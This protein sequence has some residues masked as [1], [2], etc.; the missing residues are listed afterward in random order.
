MES[1]ETP[2]ESLSFRP[3]YMM[4]RDTPKAKPSDEQNTNPNPIPSFFTTPYDFGSNTATYVSEEIPTNFEQKTY[5]KSTLYDLRTPH[6]VYPSPESVQ[7]MKDNEI[8]IDE[9]LGSDIVTILKQTSLQSQSTDYGDKSR[10]P[11]IPG[12]V[13]ENPTGTLLQRI[14]NKLTVDKFEPLVGELI[15]VMKNIDHVDTLKYSVNIIHKRAQ[16]EINFCG[17]YANMC[18]RLVN[19]CKTFKV[20]GPDGTEREN[21]FR[22]FLIN[23][24][25]ESFESEMKLDELDVLARTKL[26]KQSI[27]NVVFMGE[28]FKKN[29]ISPFVILTCLSELLKK[30]DLHLFNPSHDTIIDEHNCERLSKLFI[31]TGKMLENNKRCQS[32]LNVV[33]SGVRSLLDNTVFKSKYRQY[34]LLQD[35]IDAKENDWVNKNTSSGPQTIEAI[36]QQAIHQQAFH[37][38]STG[39]RPIESHNNDVVKTK[40]STSPQRKVVFRRII[41]SSKGDT[42]ISSKPNASSDFESNC[43]HLLIQLFDSLNIEDA[44]N[45]FEESRMNTCSSQFLR[46]GFD[47]VLENT[48]KRLDTFLQLVNILHVK[49]LIST[50]DIENG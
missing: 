30:I 12:K 9:S 4:G 19:V 26:L 13:E 20:T 21:G 11:T 22:Q 16:M 33:L 36:H 3:A 25:Q 7:I 35:I 28:L 50:N 17:M 5:T 14:L 47:M 8:W 10:K 40:L 49:S 46:I 41:Q 48:K 43:E 39:G 1:K 2:K 27:G 44:V 15:D 23:K 42:E 45:T 18:K 31:I 24:C 34:F 38:Q 6:N 32:N 37:Q 29:M